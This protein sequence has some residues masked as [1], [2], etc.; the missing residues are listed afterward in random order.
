MRASVVINTYNRAA[1]L[2]T[3]LEA[4]KLQ[5]FADF[6]VIVVNGPSTDDTEAVL[7]AWAD[8]IR[9]IRC[10]EA[11][12][13]NSRNLGVAA[14]RGDVVAFIDDDAIAEPEWLE[15]IMVAYDD[16]A[17]GAVGGY[18]YDETGFAFQWRHA[19]CDRLGRVRSYATPPPAECGLA[20]ADPF[21]YT[22]GTNCSYRRE[23]LMRAGGFDEALEHYYDDA[24]ISM[25]IIDLGYQLRILPLALVHH[26]SLGNR[27][28]DQA[29]VVVSPF[30]I[31]ADHAYFAM[32]NGGLSRTRSEIQR[33]IQTFADGMCA[34][35][36]ANLSR[37]RMT[38]E[39]H[40]RFQREMS[41]GLAAGAAR[42]LEQPR[43]RRELA[44]GDPADFKA[45][46][47]VSIAEGRRLNVCVL[48][49]ECPPK[50]FG[51]VGRY[52]YALASGL[53]ALGHVVH[54][55]TAGTEN[56]IDFENG[57]WMHRL[58]PWRR[59]VPELDDVPLQYNLYHVAA[60]Y[61]EVRRIAERMPVDVVYAPLWLCEGLLCLLDQRFPT[62]VG[63]QTA[64][65]TIAQMHPSWSESTHTKQLVALEGALITRAKHIHA[66]SAGILA[67]VREEYDILAAGG[68]VVPLGVEDQRAHFTR[69]ASDGRV[70][71]LFVSRL[72]RR[73]GVDILLDAAIR[74]LPDF[75]QLEI[76][77]VGKDTPN[78]EMAETY[79][80]AFLR[81]H[82]R[83]R[84]IAERVR[85]VGEVSDAA[86][87]QFYADCDVFCVPSRYESFGLVY[88]EAM[89]F[90]VPIVAT[91]VGGVPEV[92]QHDG[93]GFL[94]EPEDPAALA[95]ALR[96]LVADGALRAQFGRASRALYEERF[97]IPAMARGVARQLTRIIDEHHG[98]PTTNAPSG[99]SMSAVAEG[100]AA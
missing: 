100:R 87:Y 59:W 68:F 34:S 41:E 38:A 63:V 29:R 81:T 20:G 64:M 74:L 39:Q 97:T 10:P 71:V 12:L 65:K 89:M 42:A 31:A 46:P 73:K 37:G 27:T 33:S 67:K 60:A 85:F 70:R 69:C 90:G 21:V 86:L 45:Y 43:Y 83:D 55:V 72:E 36:D 3:T 11:R 84:G 6:E 16:H 58:M 30:A 35:S 22:Q 94:V 14:A 2:P 18:V 53:A 26:K 93:N 78:T 61:H 99:A 91:R 96:R 32:R 19:T 98:R 82:G 76:V 92:V 79:R 49:K 47:R 88:I 62:V 75:P 50:D 25:Q 9:I 51:G 44:P 23:A 17:V 95:E 7:A 57:I 48:S 24:E 80:E 56:R 52:T 54:F 8:A 13:S 77:V 66:N 15:R 5:T 28:R 40:A 1:S 4:L